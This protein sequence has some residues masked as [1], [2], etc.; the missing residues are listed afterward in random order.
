MSSSNPA[1]SLRLS[2]RTSSHTTPTS[3]LCPGHIQANLLVLP[4]AY[5]TDFKN[6]CL[7]NPNVWDE[8]NH[9][10]FLIGCSF[11]FEG[12]LQEA[13]LT[14]RHV[15][16]GRNVSMYAT[17]RALNPAGVFTGGQDIERVRNITKRFGRMHG[18][19]I[20]WGWNAVRELGIKDLSKPEW[21]ERVELKE[22]EVPVFWGCGVTPQVAVMAAGE[23]VEGTVMAHSPG[24]MLV[25]DVTEGEF[26]GGEEGL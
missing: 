21:G 11:S 17:T 23:K 16:T 3:G 5:A 20:A 24:H 10:A 14:P 18:E 26:F 8:E 6:L 4:R 15:E 12:A 22:G 25:L 7:R 9:I 13:G 19:P 2:C 1:A